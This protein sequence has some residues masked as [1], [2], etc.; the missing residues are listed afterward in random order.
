MAAST[1]QPGNS[2]EA[3]GKNLCERPDRRLNDALLSGEELVELTGAPCVDPVGRAIDFLSGANQQQCFVQQVMGDHSREEKDCEPLGQTREVVGFAGRHKPAAASRAKFLNHDL[4][5]Q[6]VE[7]KPAG[8][9]GARHQEGET[10]AGL[11]LQLVDEAAEGDADGDTFFAGGV[12][13]TDVEGV[14]VA[15]RQ[16]FSIE[17]RGAQASGANLRARAHPGNKQGFVLL[18]DIGEVASVFREAG[19]IA[20]YA[21]WFSFGAVLRD[22]MQERFDA[23]FGAGVA[24]VAIRLDDSEGLALHHVAEKVEIEAIGSAGIVAAIDA[25]DSGSA[26]DF[27]GSA[28]EAL[29]VAPVNA[30]EDRHMIVHW[31]AVRRYGKR[32]LFAKNRRHAGVEDR[33]V[34]GVGAA[35]DHDRGDVML[36]TK[37]EGAAADSFALFNEAKLGSETGMICGF[38]CIDGAEILGETRAACAEFS[39]FKA[40]GADVDLRREPLRCSFV[41]EIVSQEKWSGLND[42]TDPRVRF[43]DDTECA[44]K[45]GAKTKSAVGFAH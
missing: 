26:A 2:E 20:G 6:V 34:N 31:V 7:A 25:V 33:V 42:R 24:G 32:A 1:K 10:A 44:A 12:A 16:C 27:M 40:A 3:A 28:E 21:A 41:R 38:P 9:I 17:S 45:N 19:Q 13:A 29:G 39:G 43:V 18:V 5:Q 37:L 8:P 4:L 23:G 36:A 11:L 22:T 35:E 14:A 30:L 15:L